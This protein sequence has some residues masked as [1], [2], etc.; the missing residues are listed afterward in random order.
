MTTTPSAT[1]GGV[2]PTVDAVI[3]SMYIKGFV[4]PALLAP[5]VLTDEAGVRTVLDR[6]IADGLAA[7]KGPMFQL[8]DTGKGRGA[9]LAEQDRTQWGVDNATRALDSF[10]EFDH[11]MKEVVT[12]WQLRTVDGQQVMNDHTDAAYDATV[13]GDFAQLHADAATWLAP[14]P[15]GLPRMA[16]YVVRLGHAAERVAAGEHTYIASPRLDSY[17]SIWFELHEDLIRLAGRTREDEVAAGR[18]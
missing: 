8:T 6:M 13:L 7:P 16:D 10:L 9:E 17:H 11:R 2:G 18:A 14:I 15:A 1:S 12:A 4:M 5:A 3:R